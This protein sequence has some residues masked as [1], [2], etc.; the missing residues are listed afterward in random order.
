MRLHHLLWKAV[1]SVQSVKY[2]LQNAV[3]IMERNKLV[4]KMMDCIAWRSAMAVYIK[5]DVSD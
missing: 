5:A 2:S 4:I 3:G 1:L